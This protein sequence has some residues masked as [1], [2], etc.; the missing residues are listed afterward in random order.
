L[1]RHVRAIRARDA[2]IDAPRDDARRIAPRDRDS[3]RDRDGAPP[4]AAR[5]DVRTRR[6]RAPR[7]RG[8]ATPIM[9]LH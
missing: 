1:K 6:R 5:R 9:G 3:R 4:R 7:I 2:R 8:R